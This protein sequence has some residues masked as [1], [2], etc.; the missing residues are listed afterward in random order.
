MSSRADDAHVPFNSAVLGYGP[1]LPLV[2]AALGAWL[3][4]GLAFM[5]VRLAI[6]WG[7]LILAFVGGVRRGFGFGVDR[8]STASEIATSTLYFIIA[9]LALVVPRADWALAL[10]LAGFIA[11]AILD[12]RAALAGNAP[13]HFARLRP[14]QM[15]IGSIALAALWV[16][17][18][19]GDL[20]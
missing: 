18:L 17:L 9:G 8:A 14:V 4:P 16:W 12:H 10:L 2:G 15:G 3:L 13:L 1:M 19:A 20:R 11:V 6:I 7:A 5:A